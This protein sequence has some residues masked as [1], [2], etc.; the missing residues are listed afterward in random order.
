MENKLNKL[1]KFFDYNMKIKRVLYDTASNKYMDGYD[2]S[3]SIDYA[4]KLHNA[5]EDIEYY[6]TYIC[7]LF[8]SGEEQRYIKTLLE[9]YKEELFK[10]GSNFHKL[11]NFYEN[12]FSNISPVLVDEVRETCVGHY[13]F[14]SGFSLIRKAKT[15]NELLHVMHAAI[16]NNENIYG[17]IPLVARRENDYG[18][19][20]ELVGVRDD[21]SQEIFNSFPNEIFSDIVNI[22]S[23]GNKFLLMIRD[24]GH[25]LS[26]EIDIEGDE[27]VVKYF[28]PKVCNYLMVNKLKGVTP[29]RM[30]SKYAVG[31]FVVSKDEIASVISNFVR[32]VPTDD[33]MFIQGGKFYEDNNNVKR[34]R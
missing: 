5:F 26:I 31:E 1:K 13:V 32:C 6:I 34:R 27:C 8:L 28:I 23:F 20:I 33:H 3:Y 10:C 30:D 22:M 2:V 19:Y 29:V 7:N 12:C 21:I 9:V 4:D 18:K 17:D 15:V 25:A 16:V 24:V 14:N 11:R